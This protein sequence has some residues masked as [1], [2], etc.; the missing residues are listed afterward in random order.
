MIFIQLDEI[1]ID[2]VGHAAGVFGYEI[3]KGVAFGMAQLA[4]GLQK[5]KA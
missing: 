2:R 4:A 3:P 1:F 5:R